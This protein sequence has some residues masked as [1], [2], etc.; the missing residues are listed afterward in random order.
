MPC[1]RSLAQRQAYLAAQVISEK[2]PQFASRVGATLRELGELMA[3]D[4]LQRE[5]SCGG[6]FREG[7]PDARRRSAAALSTCLP[8]SVWEHKGDDEPAHMQEPLNFEYVQPTQRS[9]KYPWERA[10]RAN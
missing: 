2:S 1:G 10:M 4:A 5:E 8:R 6:H 9:Y 7:R 3:I